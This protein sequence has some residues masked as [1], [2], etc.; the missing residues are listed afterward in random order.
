MRA[1][2]SLMT[3]A[4]VI[5]I[6]ISLG[7]V[8]S[9]RAEAQPLKDVT[10]GIPSNLLTPNYCFAPAAIEMGFFEEEGLNVR[11]Q[12]TAG[13]T[14]V[15]QGVLTDQFQFGAATPEPILKSVVEGSEL[16]MVYNYL[17]G[18]TGYMAVLADS[19]YQTIGDL[20]GKRLGTASLASGNVLLTNGVL[21][22]L[23]IN[24]ETEITY[25]A[26]GV[27]AQAYHAVQTG[28][29]DALILWDTAY[30]VMENLGAKFRYMYGPGQ[31]RLFSVQLTAKRSLIESEPDMVEG[32]GRGFTKGLVFAKNNPEACVRLMWK[33]FPSSRAPGV[34][35]EQQLREGAAMVSNQIQRL[36]INEYSEAHGF[37][38]YDE[39]DVQAWNEFAVEGDIIPT[40]IEDVTKIFTNEF[41]EGYNNFDQQTVVQQ[42]K[43]WAP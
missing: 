23:G 29:V 4:G 41:V 39:K 14:A 26:V 35:E 5:A 32:F 9:V 20:R 42:A 19:P 13:S 34:P 40:E 10:L 12:T 7:I 30:E 21:A 6:T 37:G 16:V 28:H 1:I 3:A 43:D 15:V 31:E 36:V 38:S 27:G 25:L 33:M 11:V 24:P 2:G 18:P 17:R 8:G 22:R